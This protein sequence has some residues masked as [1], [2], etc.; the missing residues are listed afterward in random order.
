MDGKVVVITGAAGGLGSAT[1]RTLAERGASVVLADIDAE[2]VEAAAEELRADGLTALAVVTDVGREADISRMVQTAVDEFGG[3]NVLVSMAAPLNP[4]VISQDTSITEI[5]ADVFRHVLNVQVVG[6]LLGA[7]HAIP[8]MIA[9]GGGV[10]IHMSSVAGLQAE[11]V[12]P[13]YGTAKAALIG[14]TRS[15]ATQFGHHRVRSVALAPGVMVTPKAEGRISEAFVN[16]FLRTTPLPRLG[17]PNDVAALIA[18]LASDEAEYITGVTIPIDGG[19]L[20]P[21]GTYADELD[22]ALGREP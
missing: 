20:T 4:E 10:V 3:L 11:L 1:A 5:D 6:A 8:H 17:R 15:I 16:G 13:M 14:L 19:L 21:I 7:K 22:A 2:G 18:F 9:G 12:R